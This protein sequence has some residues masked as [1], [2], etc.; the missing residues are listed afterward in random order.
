VVIL[1]ITS[2]SL[3]V[4]TNILEEYTKTLKMGTML[5]SKTLVTFTRLHIVITQMG[6]CGSIMVKTLCYKPEGNKAR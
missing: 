5:S 2:C 1:V 4:V 3:A 6:A